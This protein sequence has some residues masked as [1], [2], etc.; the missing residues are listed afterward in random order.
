MFKYS[1]V[2]TVC[3]AY[4]T[5]IVG[6]QHAATILQ[7]LKN[8]TC[9]CGNKFL[10]CHISYV[11]Y[12]EFETWAFTLLSELRISTCTQDD[13]NARILHSAHCGIYIYKIDRQ[14][15]S[16]LILIDRHSSKSP[17][18][19]SFIFQLCKTAKDRMAWHASEACMSDLSRMLIYKPS[20]IR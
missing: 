15:V 1:T 17:C 19:R 13:R 8:G 11:N 9:A 6:L 2:R 5:N 3:V 10:K 16:L 18:F 7:S 20:I 14:I 12:H 4:I